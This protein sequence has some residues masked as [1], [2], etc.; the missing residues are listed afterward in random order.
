MESHVT[1]HDVAPEAVAAL[2]RQLLEDL[3]GVAAEE[4]DGRIHA[5]GV[6]G[7]LEYD[8]PAAELHVRIYAVPRIVTTGYVTGWLHDALL[9]GSVH[10]GDDG[11]EGSAP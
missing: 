9:A 11:A 4:D 7:A 1:F 6:H 8:E 5:R 2:R 3:E 10:K